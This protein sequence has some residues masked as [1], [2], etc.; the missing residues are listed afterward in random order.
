MKRDK[1]LLITV[2][3]VI[4]LILVICAASVITFEDKAG[5][6]VTVIGKVIIDGWDDDGNVIGASL[7]V[8][9]EN[10]YVI[11]KEKKGSELFKLDYVDVEVTGIIAEDNYGNKTIKVI[12][13]KISDKSS[14]NAE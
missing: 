3:S 14:T 7:F 1:I 12:E 9:V 10:D 5:E 6:Q 2:Y 4:A 8:S 11:L 13:Y